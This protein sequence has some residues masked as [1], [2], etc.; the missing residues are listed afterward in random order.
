MI[1]Q[2]M[3]AEAEHGAKSTPGKCRNRIALGR[4]GRDVLPGMTVCVAH[5]SHEAISM[6]MRQ[7]AAAIVRLET[8]DKAGGTEPKSVQGTLR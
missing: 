2:P 7:M 1:S 5:A 3:M 4:C 8:N 6:R